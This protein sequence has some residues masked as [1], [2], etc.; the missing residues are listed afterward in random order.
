[1]TMGA[2][3]ERMQVAISHHVD[4]AEPDAEGLHDYHYEYDNYRFSRGHVTYTTR[5][6]IDEPGQ[7][8]F[9]SREYG[10]ESRLLDIA[11]GD[12]PLLIEAVNHLRA[13]GMTVLD[14][15][16]AHDGYVPIDAPW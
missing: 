11:D 13:S 2:E 9:L 10:R 14:R 8:S 6:Y 4:A 7:A 1:M 3:F 5:A 12:D 16:T 15:L